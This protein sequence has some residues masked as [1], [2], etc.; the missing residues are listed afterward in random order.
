[1][2]LYAKKFEVVSQGA[3]IRFVDVPGFNGQVAKHL[4]KRGKIIIETGWCDTDE[5]T[6]TDLHNAEG[7]PAVTRSINT[8]GKGTYICFL[9]TARLTGRTRGDN[10]K[11]V[12]VEYERR[13]RQLVVGPYS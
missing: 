2:S 13:W 3:R 5:G 12:H 9:E 10:T 11:A 8:L 6:L 1:M 7:E 4:N